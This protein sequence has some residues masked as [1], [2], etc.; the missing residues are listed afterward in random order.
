MPNYVLLLGAGFSHN[1]DAP[2]ATEVANAL[3]QEVADN[4]HLQAL[5]RRH[6]K[7][8]ENALS[9]VQREYLHASSAEAKKRLDRL[10][11]AIATMFDRL[12]ATFE[13]PREFEFCND[14]EYSVSRFL[15]MFDSIFNLNQDLLLEMR[16][17]TR[18]LTASGARWNGSSRRA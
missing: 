18:I 10:Q 4:A 11:G 5:L 17:S 8:F 9:E 12:N 1:W 15:A 7:N 13:P 2:L 16:Y 6:S 3:L 14:R